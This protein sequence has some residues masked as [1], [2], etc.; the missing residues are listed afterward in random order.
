M[1]T[2]LYRVNAP[3]VASKIIDGEA[4]LIHFTSGHYYST[5]QAGAATVELLDGR[6]V[7]NVAEAISSAYAGD[8]EAIAQDISAFVDQLVAEGLVV[9]AEAPSASP[10]PDLGTPGPFVTPTLNRYADLQDL[11]VLDPIHDTDEAG[12]PVAQDASDA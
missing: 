7:S 8:A 11:L 6:T 3:A 4:V 9:V 10:M 5:D 12:W 1:S 2:P